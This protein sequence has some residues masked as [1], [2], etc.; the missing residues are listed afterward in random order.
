MRKKTNNVYKDS[1][2]KTIKSDF[3]INKSLYLLFLPVLLFYLIFCYGPMYGAIIGFKEF[4]PS[5]GIWGSP[6]VG[7]YHFKR[8]FGLSTFNTV[9]FNTLKISVMSLVCTFPAP[10]ILAL[11]MN[12]LRSRRFMKLVQNVTYLPNFISLVV[13]CGMVKDF[14]S[15]TGI[16]T[17]MLS[18]FGVPQITLLSNPD[19]FLPIYI[20]SA[21]WQQAGWGSIVYLSALTTIDADLYEAAS[22]DGAGKFRQLL[23][24]TL[25]GIAPT[26]IT[27]LILNVGR[28]MGVGYEK[29]LLLSND[30]IL[31][32]TEVISTYVYR[33]G[34]INHSYSYSTAVNLFNSVINIILLILTNS[35]SRKVSETSL[36]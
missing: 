36:W 30:A 10:I 32:A 25:P 13:I 26:I 11:L 8:F 35:L 24:V 21:I 7:L 9:I 31:D 16:V 18:V 33:V 19:Y 1:L 6:W 29:I 28:I 17:Q 3:R 15:N 4:S 27:S 5:K 2:Y 14:T 20:I 12:E 23:C 22:I 34:L